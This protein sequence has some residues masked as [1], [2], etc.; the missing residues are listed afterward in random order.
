MSRTGIFGLSC[1]N[2]RADVLVKGKDV[3]LGDVVTI[4]SKRFKSY[5]PDFMFKVIDIDRERGRVAIR[6]DEAENSWFYAK[7]R[8][9]SDKGVRVM[10]SMSAI[11][12]VNFFEMT[13]HEY[14]SDI[15]AENGHQHFYT[16]GRINLPDRMS[17]LYTNNVRR[18]YNAYKKSIK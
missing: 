18:M 8:W 7:K 13:R 14:E 15:M 1:K 16:Q 11:R 17:K 4:K 2:I 3:N 10:I 6:T 5:D 12:A 9:I